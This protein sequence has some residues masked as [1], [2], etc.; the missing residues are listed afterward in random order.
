MLQPSPHSAHVQRPN[1]SLHSAPSSEETSNAP[2]EENS[3]SAQQPAHEKAVNEAPPNGGYGW[4][5]VA[6]TA[7]INA[8]TW[9]VN[10][11]RP[12]LTLANVELPF[13]SADQDQSYGVFLSYYLSNDVF[14]GGTSLDFAIVG[15]LSI[16]AAMLIGT[17][18]MLSVTLLPALLRMSSWLDSTHGNLYDPP[19]WNTGDAADGRLFRDALADRRFVHQADVAALPE[20]RSL[21]RDR[22]GL[23][24]RRKRG[25]RPAMVY[26]EA[27]ARKR[28]A[29]TSCKLL[30]VQRLKKCRHRYSWQ[31]SWRPDI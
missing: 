14:A 18:M 13:A 25:D 30:Y 27:V 29:Q 22:H 1:G 21:L 6:A 4:V 2:P 9:G 19:L 12:L 11:V 24:L 5:C 20:S 23:P 7:F 8:H 16:A 10:S 26:D 3:Q 15:G 17:R 28:Y 31:R